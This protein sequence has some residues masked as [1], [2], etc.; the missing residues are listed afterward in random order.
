MC[1]FLFVMPNKYHLYQCYHL[2]RCYH[3]YQCEVGVEIR[4]GKVERAGGGLA[5][6]F[7]ITFISLHEHEAFES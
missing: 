7:I 3:L 6:G 1:V 4:A 2:Y 5:C